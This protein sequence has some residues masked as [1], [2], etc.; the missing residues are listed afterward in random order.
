MKM[1]LTLICLT[2]FAGCALENTEPAEESEANASAPLASPSADSRHCVIQALAVPDHQNTDAVPPPA[3]AP[4]CFRTFAEAISFVTEGQLD[5]AK[6]ATPEDLDA[7]MLNNV[8][9]A[10]YVIGI[11]YTA[12]NYGGASYIFGA[13]ATCSPATFGVTSMPAGWN[14][15]IS[16]AR[17]FSGCNHSYHYEHTSYT[18]A[19][20]DCGTDCSYIGDALNDRT[21][22]IRWTP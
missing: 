17:A 2:I 11:E 13:S 7:P 12:A 4:R 5:L 16:S 1:S 14:E 8:A 6:D 10:T 15:T 21:S 3:D 19:V 18:G 20:K 9:A 22:S